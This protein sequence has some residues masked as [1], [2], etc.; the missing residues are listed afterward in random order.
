M[1][2]ENERLKAIRERLGMTQ[3][4]FAEEIE[5]SVANVRKLERGD[6]LPL[7]HALQINRKFGYSLD[8][9]YGITDSTN[10]EASTMLLYLRKMFSYQYDDT[11]PEYPYSISVW[12]PVIDFL[13]AIAKADELLKNGMPQ[14]AYDLWVEKIKMDFNEAME[15]KESTAYQNVPRYRLVSANACTVTKKGADTATPPYNI[16]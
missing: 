13:N 1:G 7:S 5:T 3:E 12:P 8:Y 2:I 11:M 4:K 9:I 14:Q 15:K 6:G 16:C 10:D